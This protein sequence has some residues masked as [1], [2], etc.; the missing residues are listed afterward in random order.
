DEVLRERRLA[1]GGRGLSGPAYPGHKPPL[2]SPAHL[3]ALRA[4]DACVKRVL[5]TLEELGGDTLL[6]VCSDHGME[7]TARTIQVDDL[8]I[9]A[10]LKAG[11][12]RAIWSR[13]PTAPR[14]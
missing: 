10:G 9:G 8:L 11:R 12:T 3:A 2:G 14:P 7:T 5:D 1:L 6:L 4:A 13:R